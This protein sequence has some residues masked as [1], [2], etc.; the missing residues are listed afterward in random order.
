MDTLLTITQFEFKILLYGL[1]LVI[2][3]KMLTK[4]I[5]TEGLLLNKDTGRFSPARLQ[6]LLLTLIGSGT[7]LAMSTVPDS[8][9]LP[10]PDELFV[11]MVGGSNFYYLG[12]KMLLR[13]LPTT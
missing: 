3:Y 2:A 11:L 10:E 13:M 12:S 8:T 9:S 7:Y 6:L 1:A 4:R 5:N